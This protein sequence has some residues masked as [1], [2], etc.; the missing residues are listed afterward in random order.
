MIKRWEYLLVTFYIWEYAG[1]QWQTLDQLKR[2]EEIVKSQGL[3][4][5]VGGLW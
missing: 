1:I 5:T 3:Q 4:V 2:M